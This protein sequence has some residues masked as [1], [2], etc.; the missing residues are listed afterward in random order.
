[1][2]Q[3]LGE[4]LAILDLEQL[5]HNLYRGRSPQ[6]GWQRVF[7]GQV[8]SQALIAAQRT[9]DEERFVH[10]LHCY[11]MRPGDPAVP[12]VYQVDRLRDGG[13]FTTRRV[14]A[15]QHGHAIF[16]LECSFQKEEEGL[17]HQMEM[18]SGIPGPEQL[19]SQFELLERSGQRIPEAVRR[20]W[21]RE[22]PLEIRPVNVE[23]YTSAEKL[24]PHQQV[25]VRLTG[26][27]PDDRRLQAAILAYL[28]DMTLLETSTFAHGRIGF[29]PEMQMASLDHAMWFHR[30]H[31]LD[32]WL[33]YTQ[34]SPNAIGA[35]GF[36][37]GSLYSREGA[38]IA[39]TAQEGLVRIRAPR[40]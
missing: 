38:L 14:T 7:G 21:A 8:I 3:A 33:L 29:E 36:S 22:R 28:S 1:M 6:V 27:L 16:S 39:S 34:D 5:E 18:P 25:W 17:E 23:H 24:P 12:I 40:K 19:M 15:I 13:S 20:F 2:S 10:S 4:L 32:D 31:R 26:A 11:F 35:R 9:V 30:T 37:R